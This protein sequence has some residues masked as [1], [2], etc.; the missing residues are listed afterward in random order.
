MLDINDLFLDGRIRFTFIEPF[1]ERLQALLK[2]EDHKTSSV[3]DFVQN[4]PHS[5]FRQ[6]EENDILFVWAQEKREI[7]YDT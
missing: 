1:P 4:V 5:T 2:D 7:P 3:V 6:L